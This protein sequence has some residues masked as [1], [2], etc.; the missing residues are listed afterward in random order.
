MEKKHDRS[1]KLLIVSDNM[2]RVGIRM[3]LDTDPGLTV[4]GEASSTARAVEI[5]A[6]EEPDIALIDL[7][8]F[9]AHIVSLVRDMRKAA[10]R[11][12]PLILGSLGNEDLIRKALT[13]GAAG[14]V[15][16]VQPPAVLLAAIQSLCADEFHADGHKMQPV[17]ALLNNSHAPKRVDLDGFPPQKALDPEGEKINTLT[18]REREIIHLIAKGL[19][20]K[21]I[22]DRLCISGV[23][24]R[25]HL[26]NIFD[27]LGVSNRQKLLILAHHYRLAD[28]TLVSEAAK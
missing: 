1:V 23:T 16:K 17:P 5:A 24:V 26:T 20:N 10:D 3:I 11:M 27:K 13:S 18:T 28:L 25:H 4:V 12:L 6:R 21:D 9:G 2:L 22:A 15:L 19:A 7:D 14:V 8:L